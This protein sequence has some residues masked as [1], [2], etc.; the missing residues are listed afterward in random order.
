MKKV[1][2]LFVVAVVL[3]SSLAGASES[4]FSLGAG[5]QQPMMFSWQA[6]GQAREVLGSNKAKFWPGFG[7]YLM[8]G[9]QFK[10]P[11]Y[12][13]ISL[14][15]SYNRMKLNGLTWVNMYNADIEVAYHFFP[16]QR[17]LDLFAAA[18][19][20][21]N[22]FK[23]NGYSFKS[24]FFAPEGGFSFGL[25]YELMQHKLPS[26]HNQNLS[27]YAEIPVKLAVFLNDYVISEKKNTMMISFPVKV[28]L[29]YHF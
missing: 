27:I 10:N 28:G 26:N 3:C 5:Y 24:S 17:K 7:A 1:L 14:P 13:S 4:G 9:Y 11:D 6:P 21:V 15:I 2:G 16:P 25:E 23:T 18:I 19:V 8:P 20:G 29:N 12:L 22:Y